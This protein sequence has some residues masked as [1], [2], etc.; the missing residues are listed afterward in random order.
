MMVLFYG[1]AHVVNREQGDLNSGEGFHFNAC[2]A[3]HFGGGGSS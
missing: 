1:I 2:L 3:I